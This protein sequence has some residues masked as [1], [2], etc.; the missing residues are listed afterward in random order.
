MDMKPDDFKKEMTEY[1]KQAIFI[2]RLEHLYENFVSEY[3]LSEVSIVGAFDLFLDAIKASWRAEEE[4]D[5]E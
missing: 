4:D 5:D 1:E 2:E 3:D